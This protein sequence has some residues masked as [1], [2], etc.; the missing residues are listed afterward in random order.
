PKAK[1]GKKVKDLESAIETTAKANEDYE[2]AIKLM[3]F[4]SDNAS[5]SYANISAWFGNPDKVA[6]SG[7][8]GGNGWAAI[9]QL[10]LQM[11]KPDP[12]T[13]AFWTLY[14]GPLR[15][16][17]QF[18]QQET[19]CYLNQQWSSSVLTQTEG[20]DESKLPDLLIGKSGLVW[21]FT[22]KTAA[23]FLSNK[24]QAGY[25][26]VHVDK[27]AIPF[28]PGFVGYLNR[29]LEGAQIVDGTQAVSLSTLPTNVNTGAKILPSNVMLTLQ[30][31]AGVQELDN[32]NFKASQTFSWTV[33][34]C[35]DAVLR[36][37]V[38][39]LVLTK[40]YAGLKGFPRFLEDFKDGEHLFGPEDFP[41]DREELI[42][43]GVSAIRVRY[44][45]GGQKPVLLALKAIPLDVP[46]QVAECWA[47]GG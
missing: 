10:Q 19:A 14:T 13:E 44:A 39:P 38:G 7:T 36:I 30:C 18:M 11:G 46:Q 31:A 24:Y 37:F 4:N 42:H 34:G 43:D 5:E 2:K 1:R 29:A 27:Q 9:Q 41:D 47:P 45:I 26:P 12:E 22:G 28:A 3:A 8:S 21:A 20:V 6:S 15:L 33:G 35:G 32:Y 40:V 17:Y 23:P 16:L 25:V